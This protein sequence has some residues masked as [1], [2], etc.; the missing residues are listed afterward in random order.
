MLLEHPDIIGEFCSPSRWKQLSKESGSKI[1]LCGD[2]SCWKTFNPIASLIAKGKLPCH[3]HDDW[4]GYSKRKPKTTKPSTEWKRQSQ[5]EAKV[6]Q[7][8]KVN[9]DKVK[10]QPS[11][12]KI[13]LE[14]LNLPN[15]K[16]F[17]KYNKYKGE[18]E[19]CNEVIRDE[20]PKLSTYPKPSFPPNKTQEQLTGPLHP[21]LPYNL[22]NP[23][24]KTFPP[25]P[26]SPPSFIIAMLAIPH[27]F[28]V[29]S[30][31]VIDS[32]EA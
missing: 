21:L 13:K 3:T 30:M 25:P 32:K 24:D 6:S 5:I 11:E 28:Q 4:D 2:G 27:H 14:G 31:A 16:L 1:L 10:S 8:Q 29:I 26:L 7:S 15:L 20:G 18:I 19:F 22:Y 17:Y 23:I 9:P 12:E